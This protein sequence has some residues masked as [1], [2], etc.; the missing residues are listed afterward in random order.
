MRTLAKMRFSTERGAE[1]LKKRCAE[2]GFGRR[3]RG[4]RRDSDRDIIVPMCVMMNLLWLMVVGNALFGEVSDVT[5]LKMRISYLGR[6]QRASN[7][8]PR[9]NFVFHGPPKL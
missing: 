9:S 3:M 8:G 7:T 2:S 6:S 4:G 1:V 5:A